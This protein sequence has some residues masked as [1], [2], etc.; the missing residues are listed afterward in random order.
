MN[1]KINE[2]SINTKSDYI[3]FDLKTDDNLIDIKENKQNNINNK[4]I[5][6]KIIFSKSSNCL[7]NYSSQEEINK[8]EE[9]E[10]SI[11]FSNTILNRTLNNINNLK[12]TNKINIK[13]NL[14]LNEKQ[15]MHIKIISQLKT[16]IKNKGKLIYKSKVKNENLI[17]TGQ[18]TSSPRSN[19][20]NIKKKFNLFRN[21]SMNNIMTKKC[22]SKTLET[23]NSNNINCFI[24]K[25]NNYSND[26]AMNMPLL[27]N[28][29]NTLN[30]YREIYNKEMNKKNINKRLNYLKKSNLN[31]KSKSFSSSL[32]S[33]EQ[34]K[35][36]KI[37][38]KFV[39]KEMVKTINLDQI[40]VSNYGN[41]FLN[42][43]YR[44][45]RNKNVGNEKNSLS[46]ILFSILANNRNKNENKFEF[47]LYKPSKINISTLIE[48]NK[49]YNFKK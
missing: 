45:N 32:V 30:S 8:N 46:Q 39:L 26:K 24:F 22:C 13:N 1:Y 16:K 47:K 20:L 27:L 19:N 5:K 18:Q 44:F 7:V 33:L 42:K 48:L 9:K 2:V 6:E 29:K 21:S 37:D 36:K 10:S 40:R 38:K 49:K 14:K 23:N 31:N 12:N 17:S 34:Y 35:R 28:S 25:E 15:N 4:N 11:T 41:L 43:N 3:I